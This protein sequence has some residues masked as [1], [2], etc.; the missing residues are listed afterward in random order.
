MITSRVQFLFPNFFLPW[1]YSS[2]EHTHVEGKITQA[3]QPWVK[4]GFK[5]HCQVFAMFALILIL[6]VSYGVLM[7]G[8]S[9]TEIEGIF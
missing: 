5:G 1:F 3:L 8:D 6:I 7:T 9:R 2:G 4:M